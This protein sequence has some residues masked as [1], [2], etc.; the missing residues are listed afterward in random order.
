MHD[1]NMTFNATYLGVHL[2]VVIILK[3]WG[4]KTQPTF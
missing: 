4:S 1:Y 3:R 2:E